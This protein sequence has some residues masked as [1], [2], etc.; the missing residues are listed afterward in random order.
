MTDRTTLPYRLGLHRDPWCACGTCVNKVL[1]YVGTLERAVITAED[2]LGPR[3]I[4]TLPVR[5]VLR[6]ARAAGK[7]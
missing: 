6:R 3:T 7:L 1:Q 2:A 4:D 5:R